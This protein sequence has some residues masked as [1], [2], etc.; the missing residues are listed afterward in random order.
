MPTE[1]AVELSWI[2]PRYKGMSSRIIDRVS[3]RSDI[4]LDQVLTSKFYSAKLTIFLSY[5][6]EVKSTKHGYVLRD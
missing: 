5:L 4:I 2:N 1:K 6:V 3:E